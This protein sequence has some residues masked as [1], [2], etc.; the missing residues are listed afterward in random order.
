MSKAAQFPGQTW[1]GSSTTR[2]L[3][4]SESGEG[5][6]DV[7]RAPDGAD[8]QQI[9]AEVIAVESNLAA[10]GHANSAALATTATAGFG[11]IPK[12]AGAPT[13]TPANI[14]NGYCPIVI[15]TTDGKIYVWTGSAWHYA[16]LT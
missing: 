6:L 4:G 12:C 8:Y 16:T 9:Q 13:G 11:M 7:Y 3:T 1:D 10:Q 15:D 2:P 14:P 5:P